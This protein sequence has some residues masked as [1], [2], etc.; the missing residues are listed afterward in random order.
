MHGGV[1]DLLKTDVEFLG[2]GNLTESYTT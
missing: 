1:G 2:A